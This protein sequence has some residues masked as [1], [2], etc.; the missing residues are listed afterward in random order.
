M[1]V[2]GHAAGPTARYR[3]FATAGFLTR[4]SLLGCPSRGQPPVVRS[5]SLAAYSCGGSAGIPPA[6]HLARAR[7][8]GTVAPRC[9]GIWGD[10]VNILCL[11]KGEIFGA[12]LMQKARA[13]SPGKTWAICAAGRC[14]LVWRPRL[15][16]LSNSTEG[17]AKV[18]NPVISR[19]R[20]AGCRGR[21]VATREGAGLPLCCPCFA[22]K[23]ARCQVAATF[24]CAS[25][26]GEGHPGPAIPIIVTFSPI[27]TPYPNSGSRRARSRI[28]G[29]TISSSSARC[30]RKSGAVRAISSASSSTA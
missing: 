7:V 28:S 26:D 27:A 13:P 25:G 12:R 16:T 17:Q 11:G 22:G 6:S 10:V 24:L 14:N 18:L 1:T 5:A 29:I 2:S 23:V 3:F 4:G 20:C 8:A 9:W 15:S 30:C 21:T 19:I